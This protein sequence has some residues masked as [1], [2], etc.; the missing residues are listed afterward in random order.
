MRNFA[1]IALMAC[2]TAVKIREDMQEHQCRQYGFS[3]ACSEFDPSAAADCQVSYE[4]DECSWPQ[5]KCEYFENEMWEDCNALLEDPEAWDVMEWQPVWT[6]TEDTQHAHDYWQ[7]Y[8]DGTTDGEDS[9]TMG[10]TEWED[11]C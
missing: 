1:S 8:H 2:A 11:D 9:S 10:P 7:A 4:F 5:H 6:L 3:Y